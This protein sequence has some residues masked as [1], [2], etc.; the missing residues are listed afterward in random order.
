MKKEFATILCAV[1]VTGML[2]ACGGSGA[3]Q[4]TAAATAAP[5]ATAAAAAAAG[6]NYSTFPANNVTYICSGS[7]GG[8]LDL[9]ARFIAP[10]I[11]KYLPGDGTIT[12]E[13]V[14]GGSNW[15]AYNRLIGSAP[16]GYTLCTLA[17]PQFT[18][19]LNK[20]MNIPYTMDSY[21]PLANCVTDYCCF[22]VRADDERFADVNDLDSLAAYL[23]EHADQ[24]FLVSLTSGGGADQ[25][26]MYQFGDIAGVENLVGV[27]YADG[28]RKAESRF[29]AC[30]QQNDPS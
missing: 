17:T 15:N 3:S 14:T 26:V 13:N 7:A 6:G 12:V 4:T 1:L 22:S 28:T 29:S 30:S 20:S 2:S 25:L 10:Y 5:A 23:K 24:E 19:Y 18:N 11:Q 16:D 27:N 9:C 21:R 8:G